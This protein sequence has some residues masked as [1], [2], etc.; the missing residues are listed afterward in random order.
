MG[1]EEELKLMEEIRVTPD[2]KLEYAAKVR[3]YHQM[4]ALVSLLE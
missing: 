2:T 3:V 1:S 4:K